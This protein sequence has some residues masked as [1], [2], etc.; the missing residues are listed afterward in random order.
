MIEDEDGP[1]A[2]QPGVVQHIVGCRLDELSV[3]DFDERIALLEAEIAR[4]RA[5]K[6]KKQAALGAAASIFRA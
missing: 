5:A 3:R 1:R 2:R 4:L 6:D